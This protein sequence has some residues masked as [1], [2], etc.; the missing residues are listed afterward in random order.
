[1]EPLAEAEVGLIHALDGRTWRAALDLA[2]TLRIPVLLSANSGMD[3]E[4]AE[5]L[6]GRLVPGH[7]AIAAAT[8]PIAQRV[9]QAIANAVPVHFV[10]PGVHLGKLADRVD[11]ETP[12]VVV[13]G[14]GGFDDHV[15][16]LLKGAKQ[17]IQ[18]QPDLQLFFDGQRQ[19]PRKLWRAISQ[20]GL[21]ANATLIPR[22]LGHREVL[23]RAGALVHPQPLGRARSLTLRA[24]GHAVPVLAC[25]DPLLDYFVDGQTARVLDNP[26]PEAW[27]KALVGFATKPRAWRSLGQSAKT[28]V[29][30]NRLAANQLQRLTTHYRELT[31]EPIAFPGSA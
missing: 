23:L 27:A 26:T 7:A 18:V 30:E 1:A 15:D 12:C 8:Q 11:D 22:R 20:E 13:S 28:Y 24:M 31:G 21:L 3:V 19:D 25:N 5:R 17:A 6:A 29:A 16:R 14:N 2:A 10:P 9:E 4:L